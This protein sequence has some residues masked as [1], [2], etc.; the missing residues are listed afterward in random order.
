LSII[1]LVS[2]YMRGIS[3][4]WIEPGAMA[5]I[6]PFLYGLLFVLLQLEDYA[7]LVGSLSLFMILASLMYFT[8][9]IDWFGLGE[10]ASEDRALP[11]APPR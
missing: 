1:V 8:R 6:L 7:L 9:R 10:R 11:I 5:G 4:R 2:L 3:R